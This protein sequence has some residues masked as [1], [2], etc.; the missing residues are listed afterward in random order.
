[1]ESVGVVVPTQGSAHY[2]RFVKDEI[3]LW[4]KVIKS[5]GIKPN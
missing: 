1:M 2:T 4:T 3:D 5:A